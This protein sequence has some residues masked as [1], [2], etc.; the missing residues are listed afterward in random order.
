M[1]HQVAE[2]ATLHSGSEAYKAEAED[3]ILFICSIKKQKM[4][5]FTLEV[6]HTK[7]EAEDAI[8]FI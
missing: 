8:L 3:A 7:A 4:Q 1:K 5:P 2:G 6:K